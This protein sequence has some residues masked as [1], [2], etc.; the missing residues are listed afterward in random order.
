[1]QLQLFLMLQQEGG[2]FTDAPLIVTHN[3]HVK[4]TFRQVAVVTA[5][6]G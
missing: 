5:A 6:L 4:D 3:T 1:M 2:V